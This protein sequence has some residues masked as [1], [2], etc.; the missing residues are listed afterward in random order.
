MEIGKINWEKIVQCDQQI[1]SVL[2]SCLLQQSSIPVLSTASP[3][4]TLRARAC[5]S[6]KQEWVWS[7]GHWKWV[8]TSPCAATEHMAASIK[9]H[10]KP[11]PDIFK[12]ISQRSFF[13]YSQNPNTPHKR[14]KSSTA[15][16]KLMQH[17][18]N[19]NTKRGSYTGCDIRDSLS[20]LALNSHTA[21]ADLEKYS[22]SLRMNSH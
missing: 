13:G 8:S 1:S 18:N 7:K 11:F 21:T 5:P 2:P 4:G 12:Q 9:E 16:E 14:I 20:S 22:S 15:H 6:A 19:I 3:W 10:S 17:M